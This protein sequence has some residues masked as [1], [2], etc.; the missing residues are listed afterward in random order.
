MDN[1]FEQVFR[2]NDKNECSTNSDE[3][4]DVEVKP[5]FDSYQLEFHRLMN[6]QQILLGYASLEPTFW[7]FKNN[8]PIARYTLLVQQQSDMFQLLQ[9]IDR[10]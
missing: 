5:F 1:S 7:W 8:F 6:I 3:L 10:A 4:I 9:I 2:Q